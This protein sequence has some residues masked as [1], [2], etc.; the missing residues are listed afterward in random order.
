MPSAS[1]TVIARL[2]AGVSGPFTPFVVLLRIAGA[3][4][5]PRLFGRQ[6]RHPR[7]DEVAR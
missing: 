7:I 6:A 2:Q 3:V 5:V 1:D 4:A